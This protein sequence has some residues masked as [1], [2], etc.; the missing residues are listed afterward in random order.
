MEHNRLRSDL[1][2]LRESMLTPLG[3]ETD[4]EVQDHYKVV[5]IEQYGVLTYELHLSVSAS[6]WSI[7]ALCWSDSSSS[8]SSSI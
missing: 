2:K 6:Y 5:L 3:G 1:K 7:N 4:E 8:D